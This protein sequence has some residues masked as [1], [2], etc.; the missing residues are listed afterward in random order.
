MKIL[1]IQQKMIGDVLISSILCDNLRIA[2]PNATIDYMVYESTIAVLQGNKSISNLILFEEKHRKSNWEFLKL[3]LAIRKRRY[4]LVID[5][6]SKIESYLPVLFSG[7]KQKI[8]FSKK[9][10]KILFTDL[11]DKIQKPKSNLGL[12]IEQRL[13]LLNPLDLKID[14]K[15]FPTLDV[16]IDEIEFAKNLFEKNGVDSSKKTIML[17]IIGSALDKTYLPENMS[18]IIDNIAKSHDVNLLFNY[19][20]NQ[21]ELAKT[22]LNLCNKETQSKIYFN[23][24]GANLREFIAIMNACDLIIGND[25][26]AINIAKAL[27]KPSFIIF[28][29]WIDKKGWA[30]FED[31]VKHVSVHLKDF[32]PELCTQKSDK[33]IKKNYLSFYKE[34]TPNLFMDKIDSFLNHNLNQLKKDSDFEIK[35]NKLALTALIITYNEENNISALIEDLKFADEIIIVDSYS[36]DNTVKIAQS[37]PNTKIVQHTFENYAAQRNFAIGLATNPWILFLDADE[38]LTPALKEEIIQTLLRKK[39]YDAYYFYRTSMFK[40]SKINFSGRQTEKIF[41]LFRKDKSYYDSQ[42]TVH[43]K[44]IVSGSIGTLKHKLIHF[45]YTNYATYKLK[46]IR[47][48]IL[49]AGDEF[50]KGTNPNVFHLYIRP[51]YQFIY[52]Y[53]IRLGILDGKKGVIICFLNALSVYVRFQELKKLRLKS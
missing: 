34:F 31:G 36:T 45:S 13:S 21:I 32:K 53:I 30:T 2:F 4:N 16:T 47:Y 44:L 37:Y 14:L 10:Q 17:S 9:W 38:R 52:L 8:S 19:I 22:I 29:P 18:K 12:I 20:P 48:G 26:G 42:K 15:T 6:Y 28:S 46:M 39:H 23:V 50:V 33:E 3:L 25:G 11:V 41:R 51:M 35:Y 40:N 24:L 5:S 49:K 43:E 27:N 1:V 7:A